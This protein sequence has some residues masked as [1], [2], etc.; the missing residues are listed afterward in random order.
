MIDESR[1]IAHRENVIEADGLEGVSYLDETFVIAGKSG[2][3]FPAFTTFSIGKCD[4]RC[5]CGPDD[6]IGTQLGFCLIGRVFADGGDDDSGCV[7][8]KDA[9]RGD[10]FDLARRRF[11]C[12]RRLRRAALD[13]PVAP[14]G[15]WSASCPSAR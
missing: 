4:R 7:R 3:S 13:T 9:L 6:Q 1:A 14:P 2:R 5:T 10:R 15:I 11:A 12:D 8:S